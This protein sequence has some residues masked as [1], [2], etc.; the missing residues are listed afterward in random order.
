[1]NAYIQP[2]CP[3]LRFF[4]HADLRGICGPCQQECR[5]P[6]VPPRP[7]RQRSPR[8]RR[9]SNEESEV[10]VEHAE[11]VE[12]MEDAEEDPDDLDDIA[13]TPLSRIS[14][15]RNSMGQ[16]RA[17]SEQSESI[18]VAAPDNDGDD[19]DDDSPDVDD[20]DE[21]GSRTP[22]PTPLRQTRLSSTRPRGRVLF[23]SGDDGEEGS[24]G[25]GPQ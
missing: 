4:D 3:N 12:H 23:I 18:E 17:C 24:P 25:E 21:D 5:Q 10:Q 20:L 6:A 7:T 19:S 15:R 13:M 9:D 8:M 11:Q 22:T 1:M 14:S 2:D 16:D